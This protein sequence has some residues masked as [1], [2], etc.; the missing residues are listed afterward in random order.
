MR[1]IKPR[2]EWKKEIGE[3]A[4]HF[5]HKSQVSEIL[6]SGLI[7]RVGKASEKWQDVPAVFVSNNEGRSMWLIKEMDI[8]SDRDEN[9]RA[10]D[11]VLLKLDVSGIEFFPDIKEE[12]I[13]D[14]NLDWDREAETQVDH[15][16]NE[17]I[18]PGRILAWKAAETYISCPCIANTKECMELIQGRVVGQ[19]Y[20]TKEEINTLVYSEEEWF[21]YH[22]DDTALIEDIWK[23]PECGKICY[24]TGWN[25]IWR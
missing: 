10:E 20:E 8:L 23:C 5:T 25:Y 16:T 24:D 22:D 9:Y 13:E 7:P 3:I 15:W 14:L 18:L 17:T 19:N 12:E 6:K 2:P 21:F 1:G 11:M 4:Y